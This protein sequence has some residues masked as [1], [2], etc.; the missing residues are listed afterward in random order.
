MADTIQFAGRLPPDEAPARRTLGAGGGTRRSGAATAGA[1]LEDADVVSDAVRVRLGT[2]LRVPMYRDAYA[3]ILSS[4]ATSVVGLVYWML[5]A[6][7]YSPDAVGFNAAA[8]SSLKTRNFAQS[9]IKLN[10]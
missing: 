3:L 8:I 9:A 7:I 4:G 2:H 1:R 10:R 5:A 6:R